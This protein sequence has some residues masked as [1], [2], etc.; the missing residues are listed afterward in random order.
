MMAASCLMI[1]TFQCFKEGKRD[2]T[3]YGN[4]RAAFKRFFLEHA[5]KFS[6]I[7]GEEFYN[8]IRCGI[9]HQAQTKGRFRILRK[10]AVFDNAAESMNATL[11]LKHLKAV[12]EDYV[13]DLRVQDMHSQTWSKALQ[14]IAFICETCE[15]D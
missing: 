11:F 8:K 7:D 9:L 1:E 5:G 13:S 14:K 6:G 4:G 15:N 3:G 2:T 12:V 10:G